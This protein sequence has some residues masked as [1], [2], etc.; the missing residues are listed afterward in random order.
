M[1]G[2]NAASVLGR[3]LL[4]DAKKTS[5]GWRERGYRR[6]RLKLDCVTFGRGRVNRTMFAM[7]AEGR[8]G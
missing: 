3:S 4:S 2:K 6:D 5:S 8:D 7:K 1:T